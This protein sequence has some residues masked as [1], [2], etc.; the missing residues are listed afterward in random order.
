[1]DQAIYPGWVWDPPTVT[2]EAVGYPSGG[3]GDPTVEPTS[4][5]MIDGQLVPLF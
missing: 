5:I 4:F 1:M 3:S 2:L